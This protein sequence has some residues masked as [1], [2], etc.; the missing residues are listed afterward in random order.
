MMAAIAAAQPVVVSRRT[1]IPDLLEGPLP[2]AGPGAHSA[3][4][5]RGLQAKRGPGSSGSV[6]I[7]LSVECGEPQEDIFIGASD[8]SGVRRV[9]DDTVRARVPVW[10]ADG[11]SIYF[12]SNRSGTDAIWSVDVDGGG[13]RTVMTPPGP[14]L[15]YP[16]VS[17]KGDRLVASAGAGGN[18][19]FI[20]SL[21][22]GGAADQNATQTSGSWSGNE[23]T[24]P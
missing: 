19:I 18:G 1:R 16:L 4:K 15:L 24:E 3:R 23:A 21:T 14:G 7:E 17:P 22:P 12:Y 5:G 6:I 13:L 8:G 11:R 9:T 10:S 20:G 2:H